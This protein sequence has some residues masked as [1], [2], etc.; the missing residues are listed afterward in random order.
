MTT[1]MSAQKAGIKHPNT[2]SKELM[3]AM[4]CAIGFIVFIAL[5]VHLILKAQSGAEFNRES[6]QWQYQGRITG[7]AITGKGVIDIS[8]ES[9]DIASRNAGFVSAPVRF[10]SRHPGLHEVER[11]QLSLL[12]QALASESQVSLT[13][14]ELD[15]GSYTVINVS[16]QP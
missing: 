5:A 7:I 8:L 15:G 3:V 16:V 13:L 2:F 1:L 14:S 10:I 12:Q 4:L 6:Q 11:L 9:V